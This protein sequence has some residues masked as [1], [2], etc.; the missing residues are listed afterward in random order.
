M[1]NKEYMELHNF[2]K[3]RINEEMDKDDNS[4]YMY[5]KICILR[6]TEL[7]I[8]TI[9]CVLKERVT[10]SPAERYTIKFDKLIDALKVEALKKNPVL[11]ERDLATLLVYRE[12]IRHLTGNE[13]NI[14]IIRKFSIGKPKYTRLK[15]IK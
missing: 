1:Y 10:I 7:E 12:I 14:D 15:R 8:Y 2:I 9:L 13:P 6:F 11:T 3:N 5:Y 4:E